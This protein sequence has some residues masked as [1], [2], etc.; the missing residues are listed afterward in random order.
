MAINGNYAG[1]VERSEHYVFTGTTAATVGA[2]AENATRTL[3]GFTFAN[4]TGG[5]VQC[6][7]IHRQGG[8][9]YTVWTRSV[10]ANDT[11]VVDNLPLRLQSGDS[12]KAIGAVGVILTLTFI[13]AYPFQ[14]P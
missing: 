1:N 14:G 4:D 2:T 11:Q 10:A 13:A 5:A 6:K 12:I 8:V 9:D 7:L 3:A